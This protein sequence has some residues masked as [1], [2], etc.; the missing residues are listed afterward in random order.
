MPIELRTQDRDVFGLVY[1]GTFSDAE[2]ETALTAMVRALETARKER[3]R[4]AIVSV[5]TD[6]S[7]MSSTQRKRSSEWSKN[8]ASLLRAACVCQAVVVPG[9]IQRGVLT[10]ILWMGEYPVPIKPF[11]T[12]DEAYRWARRELASAQSSSPRP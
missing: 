11:G 7:N 10:A 2:Y 1:R 9:T 5:G 3:R 12:E 6:D 4:I 8:E